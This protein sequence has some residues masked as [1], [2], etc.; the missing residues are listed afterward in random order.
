MGAF[1]GSLSRRT[2]ARIEAMGGPPPGG[3]TVALVAAPSAVHATGNAPAFTA[4]PDSTVRFASVPVTL[5]LDEIVER[6]NA[7]QAP[8]IYGYASMLARL[9]EEQKAG[10]LQLDLLG[11]TSTSETLVP[12]LRDT[13]RSGFG[14]PI[15]D[16]FGS[17]EGLA[18]VSE[19]DDDVLI[20]NSD[21]C[22]VELVDEQN[23]PVPDGT[24]SAKVLLTNL[25]NMVQPLIRYELNDRFV[26]QPA[27][28]E[29]GH[30]R[31][32]V[33]G[34][35][36]DV[37]R[38]GSVEVHPL[39]IRSQMVRTPA[40][41]EYQV[42]QTPG[43]IEVA[44]VATGAPDTVGLRDRLAGALAAAGVPEPEV[45]VRI[46]ERLDRDPRTGKIRKFVPLR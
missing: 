28:A 43:G 16:T 39:V 7:L 13:I 44:A 24:P 36:D 42:R 46:V 45:T 15:V 4:G 38:F 30:L 8:L 40:V 11:V 34:R 32:R 9:A 37:L 23:R 20:F 17:T 5:P 33:D 6:L 22:I 25:S 26:R 14:A 31:A 12:E 27:A 3:I 2:A 19:P 41:A 35:A 21:V 18:G 10:R 1:M 29:H